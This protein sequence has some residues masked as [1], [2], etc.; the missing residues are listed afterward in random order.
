MNGGI[1]GFDL[2]ISGELEPEALAQCRVD[3]TDLALLEEYR[4]RHMRGLVAVLERIS[5]C[6]R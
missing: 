3:E 6:S 4:Q 2:E 1:S 5:N